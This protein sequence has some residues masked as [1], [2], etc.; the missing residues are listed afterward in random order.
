M[1]DQFKM[2]CED[3]GCSTGREL[4]D[5]K[6]LAVLMGP[7]ISHVLIFFH[8]SQKILN[9]SR[10]GAV[11]GAMIRPVLLIPECPTLAQGFFISVCSSKLVMS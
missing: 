1:E 4:V 3:C 7:Q 11:W 5:K 2:V 9:G 10:P 6:L 8:T